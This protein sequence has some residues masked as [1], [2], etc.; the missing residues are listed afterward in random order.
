MDFAPVSAAWRETG[1]VTQD[2]G[3]ML[4]PEWAL[5]WTGPSHSWD[6]LCS[7]PGQAFSARPWATCGG[8][9]SPRSPELLTWGPMDSTGVPQSSPGPEPAQ[10]AVPGPGSQRSPLW[11]QDTVTRRV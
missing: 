10:G 11:L 1:S 4:G 6:H 7:S 9:C 2:R 8:T 3:R 5:P